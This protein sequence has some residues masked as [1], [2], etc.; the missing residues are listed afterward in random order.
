MKWRHIIL[1]ALVFLVVAQIVHTLGA[2]LT[3][4]Y[5]ADPANFGLWSNLMMPA[6]GPP[7]TGFFVGSLVVNLA[8]G[9]VFAGVYSMLRKGI[10]GK[11]LMKGFNYGLLLF[12]LVGLPY[13]LT[14]YLLLAV[15]AM[16][17]IAWAVE[18]LVIYLVCGVAFAKL[19][20]K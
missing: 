2:M 10:P 13:T 1:S 19:I 7:G 14:T 3:M 8:I 15:P 4:G 6:E 16:L 9:L 20:T 11:G 17:L 12:V 18:S 5:Y